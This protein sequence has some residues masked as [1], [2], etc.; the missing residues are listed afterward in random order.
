MSVIKRA[1]FANPENTAA[2][3]EW[4]AGGHQAVS[5]QDTPKLWARLA[6]FGKVEPYAPPP[7]P[8]PA[9]NGQEFLAVITDTEIAASGIKQRDLLR[10]AARGPDQLPRDN[11]GLNRIFVRTGL[12]YD[13]VLG[14]LPP[15]D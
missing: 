4:E 8:P 3:I 11:A 13:A 10:I 12:T 7:A 2:I 15:R 9:F 14:R 6:E 5:L 1:W